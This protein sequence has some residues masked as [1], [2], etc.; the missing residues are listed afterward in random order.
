MVAW[1]PM[2]A[3]KSWVS[4]TD[5][6]QA[7]GRVSP[8]TSWCTPLDSGTNI[9]VRIVTPTC[10][11]IWIT[12]RKVSYYN[13][14]FFFKRRLSGFKTVGTFLTFPFNLCV[15]YRNN[16]I[17]KLAGQANTL[18]LP[19]DYGKIF[20]SNPVKVTETIE[21]NYSFRFRHALPKG[22]LCNQS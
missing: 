6:S 11:S 5:A 20:Y 15:E 8:C 21:E 10:P 19:Y 17:K 7:T 16:F 2:L 22:S 9:R 1:R 14:V 13:Q 12:S 3:P 4:T 18:G